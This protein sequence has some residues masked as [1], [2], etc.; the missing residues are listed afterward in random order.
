MKQVNARG[1]L[2]TLKVMSRHP[3]AP[4]EPPK[5]CCFGFSLDE[6]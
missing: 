4:L 6:C 5:V 1:R 2:L 3:D